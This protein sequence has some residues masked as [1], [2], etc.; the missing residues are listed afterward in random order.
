MTTTSLKRELDSLGGQRAENGDV[1]FEQS[2][3]NGVQ[4]TSIGFYIPEDFLNVALPDASKIVNMVSSKTKGSMTGRGREEELDI[5]EW[6]DCSSVA[7]IEE[8]DC[9]FRGKEEERMI[10]CGEK[11]CLVFAGLLLIRL[12]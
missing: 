9:D 4:G 3:R 8:D 7:S 11:S 1:C 2:C 6:M 12:E 5:R 10:Y